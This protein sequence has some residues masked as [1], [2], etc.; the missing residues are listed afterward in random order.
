[1][2][3]CRQTC[4]LATSGS[5]IGPQRREKTSGWLNRGPSVDQKTW[6]KSGGRS[7]TERR[8]LL[9][10]ADLPAH[11]LE[12][13]SHD[14][15]FGPSPPS[16]P[17]A[18][19]ATACAAPTTAA[20]A[21]ASRLATV[22]VFAEVA[23]VDIVVLASGWPVRRRGVTRD[24]SQEPQRRAAAQAAGV[25]TGRTL[26]RTRSCTSSSRR[27]RSPQ[28]ASARRCPGRRSGIQSR[29]R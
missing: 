29:W 26:L 28:A 2:D 16:H 9:R 27:C 15:R 25:N 24:S 6:Q 19:A 7:W 18:A 21:D 3:C 8:S 22:D 13:P 4:R 10:L 17:A 5:G 11:E 23:P 20:L 14:G 1:M 12:L